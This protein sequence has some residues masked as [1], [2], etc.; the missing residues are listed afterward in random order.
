MIY[1]NDYWKNPK[2]KL[3]DALGR[4][5]DIVLKT[6]NSL[7]TEDFPEGI[8]LIK[9]IEGNDEQNIKIIINH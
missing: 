1:N 7:S 3:I 8:Y 5:F 6:D 4:V 9:F 2:I